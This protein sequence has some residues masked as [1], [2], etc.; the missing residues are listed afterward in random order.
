[1]RKGLEPKIHFFKF[2]FTHLLTSTYEHFP[3]TAKP[4]FRIKR[5]CSSH[6]GGRVESAAWTAPSPTNETRPTGD[7]KMKNKAKFPKAKTNITPAITKAYKYDTPS[8]PANTNPPNRIRSCPPPADSKG[9]PVPP[10][11]TEKGLHLPPTL[12]TL[13]VFRYAWKLNDEW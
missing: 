10:Y 2:F 5:A 6:S 11:G 9:A 7:E 1:M 3:P 13:S 4:F 12:A 8:S